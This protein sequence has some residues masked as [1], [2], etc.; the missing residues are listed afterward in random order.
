YLVF[1][2]HG[3]PNR[4]GIA[5]LAMSFVVPLLQGLLTEILPEWFANVRHTFLVYE[6]LFIS[7]LV[8]LF[9]RQRTLPPEPGV[10][11]ARDVLVYAL[12]YYCLWALADVVIVA[13]FD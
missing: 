1:R 7:L 5:A 8:V 12:T 11:L 10:L 2:L 13:G 6:L 4:A 3:A 9:M